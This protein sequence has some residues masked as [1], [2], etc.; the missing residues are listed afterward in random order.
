MNRPD[1]W[2]TIFSSRTWGQ[3]PSLDLVR[4][5]AGEHFEEHP[6]ALE[7]GPGGGANLWPLA[8]RRFAIAGVDISP[9][10]IAQVRT[11]LDKESPG[12]IEF[13]GGLI[14]GSA[15]S[16]PF[17]ADEFDLIV[18]IE[19][20]SCLP[21]ELATSA[22]KEAYRVAKPGA[23]LFVQT[24]GDRTD[25]GAARPD[26]GGLLHPTSGPLAVVP[27]VRLTSRPR[28]VSALLG[29]WEIREINTSTRT[30]GGDSA[31]IEELLIIADKAH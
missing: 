7:L 31:L 17:G 9:S 16:L 18:D 8:L 25:V 29:A 28:E 1:D 23:R 22:Y 4:F 2:E 12:W 26:A 10:A 30:V 11:K 3:W 5:L 15:A 21:V 14:D 27:G 24:F 20:V 13:P 6:C 19:C